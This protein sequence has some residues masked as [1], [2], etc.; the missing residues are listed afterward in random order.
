VSDIKN[1]KQ[2][3]SLVL[4]D[5]GSASDALWNP[6]AFVWYKEKNLL[7]LPATLMTPAGSKENPY[8][9]GSAFEGLIGISITPNAIS[10]KFRVTH[11]ALPKDLETTWKKECAPY[12]LNNATYEIY[13]PEYCKIG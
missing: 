13:I 3:R 12:A 5:M 2:E 1:P 11:V 7:L 8:L 6:K 9:Y 4:G 10:E